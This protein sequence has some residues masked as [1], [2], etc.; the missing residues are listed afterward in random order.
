MHSAH[1]LYCAGIVGYARRL[2]Q[3]L[4]QA[5][6]NHQIKVVKFTECLGCVA[7]RRSKIS[8][9]LFR[10]YINGSFDRFAELQQDV[11]LQLLQTV[12]FSSES[13]VPRGATTSNVP[14]HFASPPAPS[15]PHYP[16]RR[17]QLIR[18]RLDTTVPKCACSMQEGGPALWAPS[19]KPFAASPCLQRGL[20]LP[21]APRTTHYPE[22]PPPT[23]RAIP[24]PH[25]A[26]A[27]TAPRV[28]RYKSTCGGENGEEVG[29]PCPPPF[30]PRAGPYLSPPFPPH[31][32]TIAL[33][34]LACFG[35]ANSSMNPDPDPVH[36]GPIQVFI[37]S[38]QP[39]C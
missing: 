3:L 18:A 19:T 36:D 30:L 31:R 20:S 21:H 11:Y 5:T 23:A 34:M 29:R 12:T 6:S 37:M 26:R 7:H 24:A 9:K 27:H 22:H 8:S 1:S 10:S 35:V 2:H 32:R 15:T 25:T 4:S 28:A 14:A 17:Y 13:N 16:L 38:G 39:A 33:L